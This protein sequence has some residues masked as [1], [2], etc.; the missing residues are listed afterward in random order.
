ME[1]FINELYT[2]AQLI[3]ATKEIIAYYYEADDMHAKRQWDEISD[4]YIDFCKTINSMDSALANAIL[5]NLKKACSHTLTSPANYCLMAN[6][7]EETLP[8]VY[9]GMSLLGTIDVT[10]GKYRIQSSKSGFLTLYNSES[11]RYYHDLIDPYYEAFRLAKRNY[12]PRYTSYLFLGCGLGYLPWQ[13]FCLSDSSADI[14]I[15][16]NDEQVVNYSLNYGVLS[17]IP[18]NKLHIYINNDITELLNEYENA[19]SNNAFGLFEIKDVF[20]SSNDVQKNRITQLHMNSRGS[21]LFENLLS[22]NLWRNVT[23]V[24]HYFDE[25]KNYIP[26][27]PWIVVAAGPS[28]DSKLA[29]IKENEG[30]KNIVCASTVFKKLLDNKITPT[31]VTVLDPQS[32]T[33]KHF[34]GIES[35]DIPLILGSNGNWQFGEFY[36]GPKFL[37]PCN[38]DQT[39][40]MYF[41]T[42]NIPSYTLGSTVASMSIIVALLCKATSVEMIGI[43]LSFPGGFTH[44]QGTMDCKPASKEGMIPVTSVNGNPVYTLPNFLFYAEQINQIIADN[45]HTKFINFSDDGIKFNNCK[46]YK[47]LN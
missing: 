34:E 24:T 29:Y 45:P 16:H 35:S 42:K 21:E 33:Y 7:L 25:F 1:D 22:I 13:V 14:Y 36:N 19:K 12:N 43:D 10:E 44:A 30:K 41:K 23:N 32:R 26:N 37:L 5:L 47:E 38:S 15:Y 46:W 9:K 28:L 11:K 6:G 2:Y 39:T 17:F 8:L 31:C 18:E 3:P 40:I 27:A 4:L 20:D